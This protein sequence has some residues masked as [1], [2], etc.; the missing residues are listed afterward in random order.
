MDKSVVNRPGWL[1][2][3]LGIIYPSGVILFE[4]ISR[5][6]A[7]IFFDPLPTPGHLL[8]VLLVPVANGLLWWHLR[9]E[10]WRSLQLLH[11]MSSVAIGVAIYYS[12]IFLPLVPLGVIAVM[13]YGVGLLPL[14][15]IAALVVAVILYKRFT[16]HHSQ[17]MSSTSWWK[18]AGIGVLLLV[19]LDIPAA[20]TTWGVNLASSPV[21]NDR[22]FGLTVLRTI[23]DEDLLLR[24]CYDGSRQI[25]GPWTLAS[26]IF[27]H[28][29]GGPSQLEA[30]E[31]YYRVTGHPFNTVPLPYES[32]SWSRFDDFQFDPDLGGVQV[33]GRIRDLRLL[34]S[35]IEGS[36][37]GDDGLAYMEWILEFQNDSSVQR[38]ARVQIT[39]PPDA[40]VSRASL[41]IEGEEREAAFAKQSKVRAAYQRVVDRRR[42]P[43]LVTTA[44]P[45]VCWPKPFPSLNGAAPSNSSWEL[46]R[47]LN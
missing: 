16:R 39:L 12:L 47:H 41:W 26:A 20:T 7:G 2:L 24:M 44:G 34:S 35:R 40:V 6:C 8:L 28:S 17:E 21:E 18:G 27:G 45:T 29:A 19:L 30:R 15:P 33:G 31:I 46:R 9:E 10:R 1:L 13:F 42:D 43:L 23:G 36:V 38:E 11:W 32:G 4:W 5:F 3:I 22:Q 25:L 37:N 14:A